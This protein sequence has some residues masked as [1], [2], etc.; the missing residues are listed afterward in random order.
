MD[1]K[2]VLQ[3]D[4][5]LIAG[6]LILLSLSSAIPELAK[7]AS[8]AGNP[9]VAGNPKTMASLVIVTFSSSASFEL[10]K[11]LIQNVG[12][13]SNRGER[14][15]KNASILCMLFGFGSLVMFGLILRMGIE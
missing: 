3:I 14:F 12:K 7:V 4:A 11:I 2:D 8:Y 5:T 10:I 15:L 9:V 6:I 1:S 13:L